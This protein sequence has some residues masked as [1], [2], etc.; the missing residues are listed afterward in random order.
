[1]V[2]V[3]FSRAHVQ[4]ELASTEAALECIWAAC[5]QVRS[6]RRLQQ[7]FAAVLA[8]GNTLNGGSKYG[9]AEAFKLMSLRKLADTRVSGCL[10]PDLSITPMSPGT[11]LP[12]CTLSI[13]NASS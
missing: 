10:A 4:R 1:M 6:S 7:T 5:E 3:T 11:T 2:H 12:L 8:V 9:G 13:C